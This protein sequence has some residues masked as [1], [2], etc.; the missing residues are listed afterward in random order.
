MTAIN[1]PA[2][3]ASGHEPWLPKY[4]TVTEAAEALARP[5]GAVLRLIHA[6]KLRSIRLGR[7]YRIRETEVLRHLAGIRFEN[8]MLEPAECACILRCPVTTIHALVHHGHLSGQPSREP[9]SYGIPVL[10]FLRFLGN[11]E[12]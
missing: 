1:D 6:G 7:S 12:R 9:G 4:L 3:L 2:W 5:R 10:E 11:A 8:E